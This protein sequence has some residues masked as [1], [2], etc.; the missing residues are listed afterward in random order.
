MRTFILITL[1]TAG[2]A[3]AQTWHFATDYHYFDAK[4]N[5][6]RTERVSGD[7]TRLPE[8]LARWNNVTA[9]PIEAPQKRDFMEGFTYRPDA[10]KAT[11]QPG[12]FKGFPPAAI[13]ARNLVWDTQMI[14]GF[15]SLL[16][17]KLKPN[18]IYHLPDAADLSLGALGSFHHKDVQIVWTGTS[19][20]N[21]QD[22]ALI[23]Y[24]ALFNQLDIQ[25]PGMTL[26]GRSDYWGQIWVSA[27]THQ[28]EYATLYE[29]VYGE[30]VLTGQ[31]KPQLVAVFRVGT[32]AP[33]VQ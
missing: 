30:V 14:E 3:A 1:L 6:V 29:E 10:D 32:L 9:G 25:T 23:D 28:I 20:R 7:Y 13:E 31:E 33:A 19:Q 21:G 2:V 15:A 11:L 24:R 4:G 8:G 27:K 16:A 5:M 17:E 22:C 12:F 26:T 18:Q